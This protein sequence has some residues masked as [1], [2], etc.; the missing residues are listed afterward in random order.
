M[1]LWLW[2]QWPL[3]PC[4]CRRSVGLVRLAVSSQWPLRPCR[5]RSRAKPSKKSSHIGSLNGLCGRCRLL[6]RAVFG[7]LRSSQWPLRPC[8]CRDRED[9]HRRRRKVSMASAAVPVPESLV[10]VRIKNNVSMASAAVPL[11]V[12]ALPIAL[13]VESQWPLRPC[14]CRKIRLHVVLSRVDSLNGLCGRAAAGDGLSIF[15]GGT[16]VSMASAA[17]PLPVVAVCLIVWCFYKSQWP[18]RP[19]RCRRRPRYNPREGDDVSMASAA[20]PLPGRR[21]RHLYAGTGLN[22]LCGRAAAGRVHLLQRQLLRSLNGLCGHAAAG[23]GYHASQVQA[24][25]MASAA[26][27]LPDVAGAA[28]PNAAQVS[29]ASAAVP[30]PVTLARSE[31]LFLKVSMASAAVPLPGTGRAG[32]YHL[33]VSMASAAVPLPGRAGLRPRRRTGLNGLCGRAAAGAFPLK[34]WTRLRKSQWPLRPC[35]CRTGYCDALA[36]SQKSQW[37]LRP[38]RCRAVP[39]A[40]NATAWTVSMASAAVPLPG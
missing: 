2:S 14:R 3:R 28:L 30:L 35:R 11:P 16:P 9:R 12:S 1:Q 19:C 7:R 4:R 31:C 10:T 22:G 38:C 26:V 6:V 21:A 33:D 29:M 39:E 17:V 23:S 40:P 34:S 15:S 18:L 20:V 25:S 8:R 36:D 27:P 5:C 13:D 24:V 37:P 32:I